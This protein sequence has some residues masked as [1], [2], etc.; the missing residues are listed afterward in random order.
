MFLSKI[1]L[2]KIRQQIFGGFYAD[3]SM[4]ILF[5]A[6]CVAE[7]YKRSLTGVFLWQAPKGCWRWCLGDQYI[8]AFPWQQV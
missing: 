8:V 7:Q 2:V 1:R 4:L 3:L 5:T 6:T